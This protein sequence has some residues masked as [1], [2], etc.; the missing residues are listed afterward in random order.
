METEIKVSYNK[1]SAFSV[2]S[3]TEKNI[4]INV[5]RSIFE[6]FMEGRGTTSHENLT[7]LLLCF[8]N[9]ISVG[10]K[11]PDRLDKS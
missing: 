9:I 6:N 7:L 5:W 1:T 10:G 11:S 2:K 3:P 8:Q 4:W